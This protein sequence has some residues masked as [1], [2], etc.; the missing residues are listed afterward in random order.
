[1]L[2]NRSVGG[3][4]WYAVLLGLIVWGAGTAFLTPPKAAIREGDV[5]EVA[6]DKTWEVAYRDDDQPELW[7]V[8]EYG[9]NLAESQGAP[10]TYLMTEEQIVEAKRA[11]SAR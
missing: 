9:P 2:N 5:I 7:V 8:E 10:M 1:M 11:A 6:P 4:V 3:W